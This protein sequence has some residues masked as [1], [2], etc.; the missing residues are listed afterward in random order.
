MDNRPMKIDD[1]SPT[2]VEISRALAQSDIQFKRI[3]PVFQPGFVKGEFRKMIGVFDE[4]ELLA[5]IV[6]RRDNVVVLTKV[7]PNFEFTEKEPS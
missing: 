4:I 1:F 7:Q 2:T 6:K 3:G 5:V